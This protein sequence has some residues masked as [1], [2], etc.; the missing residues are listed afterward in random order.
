MMEAYTNEIV[1]LR[2]NVFKVEAAFK[3]SQNRNEEDYQAII[4]DLSKG[5]C[6]EQTLAEE[7]KK[8]RK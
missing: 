4:Q 6:N 3:L 1:G 5:N 8:W 7:M 2:L